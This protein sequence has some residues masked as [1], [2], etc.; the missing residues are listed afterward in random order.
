MA[1]EMNG[2]GVYEAPLDGKA[3]GRR[4]GSWDEITAEGIGEAP[5]DGK[6]YVRKDRAWA[7]GVPEVPADGEL[8]A[9]TRG[10]WRKII[11]HEP[12]FEAPLDGAPYARRNKGWVVSVTEAPADGEEYVRK[13]GAWARKSPPHGQIKDISDMVNGVRRANQGV[14]ASEFALG[15]VNASLA[16]HGELKNPH[17]ATTAAAA[18][19]LVLR[20]GKGRAQAADPAVAAD[21]ANKRY[22]DA[23]RANGK[24]GPGLDL[25]A[26][27]NLDDLVDEGWYFV[28]TNV[29]AEW[30][31]GANGFLYV[32][33]A[34]G[35][36]KQWAYRY[37]SP[38]ISDHQTAIRTRTSAG[39]WG[40]WTRVDPQ[41]G[42]EQAHKAAGWQK[43]P[44]GLILQWGSG[45]FGTAG[46][47]VVTF[48]TT[49]PNGVFSVLACS[50]GASASGVGVGSAPSLSSAEF[51]V[52]SPGIKT[53]SWLAVGR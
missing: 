48:P 42:W 10:A 31:V 53:F 13:D 5:V 29:I 27:S 18:D 33:P 6:T 24:S 30:P 22:V 49:F 11:D 32:K 44:S 38:G 28:D 3:Y 51:I 19:R 26:G 39:V 35:R 4:S 21:I 43:L 1:A 52:Q 2:C 47:S 16:K 41:A 45:A 37:G 50:M 46:T 9:R 34:K 25:P 7:S 20:D 36:V 40:T 15:Q 14:V 17:G 12:I 23:L 8:Y